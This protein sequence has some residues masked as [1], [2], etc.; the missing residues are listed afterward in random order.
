MKWTIASL[1]LNRPMIRFKK[2][3]LTVTVRR[4]LMSLTFST[5]LTILNKWPQLEVWLSHQASKP[6]QTEICS[7]TSRLLL[8]LPDIDHSLRRQNSSLWLINKKDM[9]SKEK[10]Q[11][12]S[13]RMMSMIKFKKLK[14]ETAL[15]TDLS[16][17]KLMK[18]IKS[19]YQIILKNLNAPIDWL[20]LP[21]TKTS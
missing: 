20:R 3:W 7:Q 17:Q 8:P 4:F 9:A 21:Q 19:N 18:T 6:A 5:T 15:G 11:W 10:P 12:Y 13:L 1:R 2:T 14:E 16:N